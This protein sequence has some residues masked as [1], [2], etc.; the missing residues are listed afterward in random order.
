MH[1]YSLV[2]RFIAATLFASAVFAPVSSRA[3]DQLADGITLEEIRV[4]SFSTLQ[5]LARRTAHEPFVPRASLPQKLAAL[6]Y[7]Q[8]Q[9][10]T[11]R[12]DRG[13]WYHT[14]LP[15]WLETF[16]RGFVQRDRI[17]LSILE[18]GQAKQIP[19]SRSDFNYETDLRESAEIA[20]S[21]HAG[22]K[23]AGRFPGQADGQEMLT[24]LGSS[25]FRARSAQTLYGTSARG[26]AVNIAL[27]QDE[28]FPFFKSFWVTRPNPSDTTIQILALMDSPSLVGAY[29]FDFQPDKIESKLSV[30]CSIFFRGTPEKVGIAPLTSMWM[31]GDGLQGP[32][33][34]ARPSVHDSD[35]LLIRDD[36]GWTWRPFARQS[37]P[38]VSK[39]EINELRGFGLMQRN[40]AFYHYDDHN[41][42]YEK[43]PS[44]YVHPRSDWGPGTIEL[45]ELPGAHE[46]VDNIAA[47]WIPQRK[48]TPRTPLDLRYDVSFFPG[49][50]GSERGI[51]R[52]TDLAIDRG[53]KSITATVRFS[54][55][56]L[57]EQRIENTTILVQTTR[58][59]VIS[60]SLDALDSGDWKVTLE[61]EPTEKAPVEI[62]MTLMDHEK[63]LSEHFMYLCPPQEPEFVYPAVYTRVE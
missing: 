51:A 18:G 46:G 29:Q 8:Y 7:D 2:R 38:S 54:G 61:L 55:E 27:N 21:G 10:I 37:Y 35:G 3:Q 53:G 22:F 24:F 28:E 30:R 36:R 14:G 9:S 60:K 32:A 5:D 16:H 34:D 42:H 23:V 11:F 40:R 19:F 31:W 63:R 12:P 25:Y 56:L 50:H 48:L 39:F 26:L 49:D 20:N 15:F 33:K 45:L 62:S 6:S 13:I 41:A 1:P 4:E 44:V 17:T 43:R 59:N 47:Y 52:A 58:G 57:R